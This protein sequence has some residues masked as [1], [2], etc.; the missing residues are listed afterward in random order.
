[1]KSLSRVHMEVTMLVLDLRVGSLL[2]IMPRVSKEWECLHRNRHIYRKTC[3]WILTTPLNQLVGHGHTTVRPQWLELTVVIY[4]VTAAKS[5]ETWLNLIGALVSRF[6]STRV[7]CSL[8]KCRMNQKSL[9]PIIWFKS[10]NL[11]SHLD[12]LYFF[13]WVFAIYDLIATP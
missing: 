4:T 11:L 2:L 13:A 10:E 9:S 7:V 5:H 12:V 1:M 8:S 3:R 6:V